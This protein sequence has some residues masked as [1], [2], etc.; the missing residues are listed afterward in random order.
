[1]KTARRMI[2]DQH[3]AAATAVEDVVTWKTPASDYLTY[4]NT[5][6]T[7]TYNIHT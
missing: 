1:M 7:Y 4:S 2:N 6:P 3:K 5:L